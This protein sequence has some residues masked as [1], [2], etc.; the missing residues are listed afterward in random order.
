[1]RWACTVGGVAA[2]S[3]LD[4]GCGWIVPDDRDVPE[5]VSSMFDGVAQRFGGDCAIDLDRVARIGTAPDPDVAERS[6]ELYVG[7]TASGGDFQV[8]RQLDEDEAPIGDLAI[9]GSCDEPVGGEISW[10]GGQASGLNQFH[11][12]R[13]PDGAETV[14]LHLA[15]GDEVTVAAID[16]DFYFAVISDATW[17]EEIPQPDLVEALDADGNVIAELRP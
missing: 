8:V 5:E 17:H 12:G 9:A 11:A 2:L 3:L 16:G 15:G 10:A 14:E 4:A 13:V 1:M 6:F 7:A